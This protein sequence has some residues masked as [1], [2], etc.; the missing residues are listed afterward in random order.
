MKPPHYVFW[1]IKTL[2]FA[3]RVAIVGVFGFQ[4]YGDF[5][6]LNRFGMFSVLT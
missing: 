5:T 3:V 2:P 6:T 4:H 1:F